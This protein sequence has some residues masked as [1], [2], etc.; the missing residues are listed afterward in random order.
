MSG[1]AFVGG[2]LNFYLHLLHLRVGN[3]HHMYT[4]KKSGLKGPEFVWKIVIYVTAVNLNLICMCHGFGV[5][6]IIYEDYV[7]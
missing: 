7:D 1:S 3:A 5:L 4:N 6:K 2:F